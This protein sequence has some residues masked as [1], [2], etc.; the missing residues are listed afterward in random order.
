MPRCAR[1]RVCWRRAD[2]RCSSNTGPRPIGSV[3]KWQR[4]IEPVWK[5]LAGG[6]HLTRAITAPFERAGFAVERAGQGYAP[7]TPRFAG[8][9]EW[10]VARPA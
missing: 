5:P 4:R 8:W 7:K 3:A 6:C 9:M 1:S 10:G 2:G